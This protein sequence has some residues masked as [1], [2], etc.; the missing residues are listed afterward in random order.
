MRLSS[1]ERVRLSEKPFETLCILVRNAGHLVSKNELLKQVWA[2]TFV[3]ENNLNKSIHAV[4][5][6]LGEKTGEQQFIET[7]KKHGFRF[8]AEVRRIPPKEITDAV[9]QENEFQSKTNRDSSAEFSPLPKQ[10]ETLKTD[11]AVSPAGLRLEANGNETVE[12]VSPSTTPAESIEQSTRLGSVSQNPNIES[13][14]VPKYRLPLSAFALAIF[15]IGAGTLGYFFFAGKTASGVDGKKQ[16][17]VLPF[18]HINTANRDELYEIGIADSLI[19][20][21][22]MMKGFVVRPLS[23]TR[24]YADIEQDSLIAGQ[25][26][27]VDY[28]LASNYQLAG[29]KIKVTSQLFNVANGQIEET[30]T[31]EK[32]AGDVFTMQDAVA[33]EVGNLLSARFGSTANNQAAKRGTTNEEA[34]RLYL[35]GMYLVDK[36]DPAEAR[37]AVGIFEQAVRL[38]PNY[39]RAWAGKAHAHRYVASLGRSANIHEEYQNSMTAINKAL[40]LD[41]N[42]ADA[43]S[44]LCEYKMYYEWDFAGAQRSCQRALELNPNS[45][46]AHQ[47]YSHYMLSRGRSDEAIAEIKTAIDLEPTSLFN[48]LVYGI[49]LYYA[50]RY[51]EAALQFKRVISMNPNFGNAYP[52]LWQSLEM[53]GKYEEAFE[54]FMKFQALQKRDN[55][56]VQLFK[57]AYQ[58]S[59]WQGVLGEQARQFE[60]GNYVISTARVLTARS[61]I[62]IKR[63]NIWKNRFSDARSG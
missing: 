33:V 45:S 15:L 60:A 49:G 25:E 63:L 26:Q 32:D 3:E 37:K 61:G 44:A 53:Q 21:L 28:V 34:Y 62:R 22:G 59:G 10:T 43:H 11:V 7:V 57:T 2:D 5:R 14:H 52:W 12:Q 58:T 36:L 30:Y 20:K 27:K 54:W 38:D 35:E 40:A 51:D 18:K 17:A 1:G 6:A 4:R 29:G 47:I 24:K 50:R 46:T 31:I 41:E 8:V 23:A 55:E 9:H 16:I 42:L 48:Q 56:A 13:N 19:H 39:A